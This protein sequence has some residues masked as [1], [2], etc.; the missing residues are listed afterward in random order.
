MRIRALALVILSAPLAAPGAGPARPSAAAEGLLAA[1]AAVFA[2][3]DLKRQLVKNRSR[4]MEGVS[5]AAAADDGK[6]DAAAHRAAAVRGA[7]EIAKRIRDHARF[8]DVAY[9]VGGL[10][11]ECAAAGD[12]L[13]AAPKSARFLGF[14]ADPFGDPAALLAARTGKEPWDVALT[15]ATCLVA[16]LWKSAGGDSSIASRMPESKGPY[17]VRE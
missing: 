12:R 7:R 5:D 16:W 4:L 11:H 10:V 17:T 8:V 6:R 13:D 1:D 2:P 9:E 3:P 14:T 15:R